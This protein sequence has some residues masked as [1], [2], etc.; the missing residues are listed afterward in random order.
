M[1][2]QFTSLPHPFFKCRARSQIFWATNM[3]RTANIFLSALSKTLPFISFVLSRRDAAGN[4]VG[5]LHP[6]PTRL[7]Y[8][9]HP[10]AA[11]KNTVGCRSVRVSTQLPLSLYCTSPFDA[12]TLLRLAMRLGT[13]VTGVLA[14]I[15]VQTG[16][17]IFLQYG[18]YPLSYLHSCGWT[19]PP[20]AVCC[21]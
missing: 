10:S 8:G 9:R 11:C 19:G 4:S 20:G 17:R 2:C 14:L 1:E 18:P 15:S 6:R 12:A 5:L 16:L 21:R 7:H 3:R 13:F